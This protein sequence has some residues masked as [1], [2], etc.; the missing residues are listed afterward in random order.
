MT[1]LRLMNPSIYAAEDE[2][3][4]WREKAYAGTE[5]MTAHEFNEFVRRK[6]EP[7]MREFHL[8]T[9]ETEHRV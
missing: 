7:V 1:E 6:S 5:G 4:K 3:D 9:A 2:V 8:K